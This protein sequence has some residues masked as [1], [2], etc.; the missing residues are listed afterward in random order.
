AWE[1]LLSRNPDSIV[2]VSGASS[3]ELDRSYEQAGCLAFRDPGRAV[4]A[5]A[6]LNRFRDSFDRRTTGLSTNVVRQ[7]LPP[8]TLNEF[9]SLQVLKEAGIPTVPHRIVQSAEEA[10]IA[11]REF[12]YP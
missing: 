9:R 10:V 5:V 3:A 4:R 1:N 12:G 6:A 7:T 2:A 11:A 8:G